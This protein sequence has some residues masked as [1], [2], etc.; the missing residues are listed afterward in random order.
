MTRPQAIIDRF[1]TGTV[2]LPQAVAE[3]RALGIDGPELAEML[4]HALT[5][6]MSENPRVRLVTKDGEL[7]TD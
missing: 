4:A 7:L 3:L 2:L 5:R 6:Y 1:A